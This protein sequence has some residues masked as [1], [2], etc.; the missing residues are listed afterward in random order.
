[1]RVSLFVL[2]IALQLPSFGQIDLLPRIDQWRSI[3]QTHEQHTSIALG[4]EMLQTVRQEDSLAET[5][6]A[7]VSLELHP[8]P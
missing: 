1:M 7:R 8:P 6:G 2:L 5:K 3:Q 4:E